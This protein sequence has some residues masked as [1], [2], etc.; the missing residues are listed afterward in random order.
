MIQEVAYFTY[1]LENVNE[2]IE[3]II[4]N[5]INTV[6]KEIIPFNRKTSE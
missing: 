1:V 2:N 5:Y 3:S 4:I 6:G